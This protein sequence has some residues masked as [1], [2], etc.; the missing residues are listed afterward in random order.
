MNKIAQLKQI[1]SLS[2]RCI[3][4]TS[5]LAG[6]KNFR[7]FYI[8]NQRGTKAF[9]EAQKTN[10]HPRI[11]I[12][13]YGVRR[14]TILDDYGYPVEMNE[15]I[16]ELIVPDLTD[17]DLKPYVSY[18]TTQ[19]TQTEFTADDLFNSVYSTKLIDDWNNKQ[20][21]EDGTSK[22]PSEDELLDAEEALLRARRTGSDIFGEKPFDRR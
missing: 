4:T 10:P 13:T 1:S 17:F 8:P 20:L 2:H 18:R 5:A 12:E 7:K 9:R 16:P 11:P 21:N 19:I 14:T 6:K 3:S 15:K 22:N